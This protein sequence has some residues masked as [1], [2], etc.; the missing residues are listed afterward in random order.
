MCEVNTIAKGLNH[1]YQIVIGAHAVRTG[2]HSETVIDTINCFF[3]P[4][5]IFNGR[6]DTWQTEDWPWR[7]VRMHCQTYANF[8]S[9]RHNRPQEYRHIIAQI[10]FADAVI[11]S[12]TRAELIQRISLFGTRQ[13]SDNVAGQLFNV[14][15][16]HCIEV[17][18]RLTL[19]FSGVIGFCTRTLQNVQFKSRE[20][21]LVKTQ[22]F[23]SI[24]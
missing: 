6:H 5:H 22:C 8:L 11:F 18:Q 14:G 3:Q 21:N 23:G 4:L 17:I 16:G 15:S 7:I 9:N 2:T 10:V 1:F 20:R 24:R 19:L 13:A 12:K